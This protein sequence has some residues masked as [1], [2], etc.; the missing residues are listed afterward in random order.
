ME[1]GRHAARDRRYVTKG[2]R[3]AGEPELKCPRGIIS[4]RWA[5]PA[6]FIHFGLMASLWLI[7][8][9]QKP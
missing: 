9:A 6:A 1:L 7:L 8:Y 4:G 5:M 2:L 3:M